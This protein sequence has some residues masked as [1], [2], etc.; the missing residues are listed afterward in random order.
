DVEGFFTALLVADKIVTIDMDLYYYWKNPNG[1]SYRWFSHEQMDL[2]TVWKKVVDLCKI[3][4]SQWVE[5][6]Q[7]NYYRANMGLLVRLA[8]NNKDKDILFENE[9]KQLITELKKHKSE[10]LKASF[11]ISRKLLVVMFCTNYDLTRYLMRKG[12]KFI[13]ISYQ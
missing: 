10:L 7:L 11:P 9:K 5:Y 3:S 1:I 4:H 12:K 6:A 13:N 8:L 2:L